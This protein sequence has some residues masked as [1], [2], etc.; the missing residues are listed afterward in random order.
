MPEIQVGIKLRA[1]GQG[2]VGEVRIA[3]EEMEKLTKAAGE[4]GDAAKKAADDGKR[5]SESLK[6]VEK[7]ARAAGLAIAAVSTAV[8]YKTK[9][10]IDN[11]AGMARWQEVTGKSVES[12]AALKYVA[13]Q[14]DV[15]FD[16]LMATYQ[17]LPRAIVEG[18]GKDSEAG[19]AFR[20]IGIDP[21]TIKAND[22]G[23]NLI[24]DRLRQIEDR[25]VRA[26]AAQMIFKQRGEDLLL[27]INQGSE[28]L[29]KLN[30]EGERWNTITG[31]NAQQAKELKDN[32]NT[33]KYGSDALAASIADNTVPA[34]N[35]LIAR[36][37]E[38]SKAS[39]SFFGALGTA[40]DE[41]KWSRDFHEATER[42]LAAQKNLD[43]LNASSGWM[44][45]GLP[46][47]RAELEAARLEVERLQRIKPILI[48]EP[49][50]ASKPEGGAKPSFKQPTLLDLQSTADEEARR[51]SAQQFLLT[52]E[53]RLAALSGEGT[54]VSRVTRELGANAASYTAAEQEA[55]QALAE[56]ID[57]LRQA[58]EATQAYLAEV[59]ADEE[60]RAEVEALKL[61]SQDRINAIREENMLEIEVLEMHL[62]QKR[63][64]VEQAV[65]FE[66][67]SRAEADRQLEL[68][69]IQHQAKLGNAT[70]QGI[71]QRRNLERMGML[72]QAQ[73]YFGHLQQITAAGAQHSRTMFKINQLA[74]I[75]NAIIST[76][77][78]AAK[79]LKWGFPLGPIFAGLIVAAGI[80]QIQA[81]RRAEFGGTSAPSI[82][83]GSAIPVTPA[84]DL[85]TVAAPPVPDIAQAQPVQRR[86]ITITFIGSGRYTQEE[87]RES[88]MPALN[89]ALG[90]GVE[91]R[92]RN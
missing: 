73:F 43:R 23:M 48:P 84:A 67:I 5:H 7:S 26:A 36:L 55:A 2:L 24:I 68:L 44:R 54:E 11:A 61:R 10:W 53:D 76:H 79:A 30:Q 66:Q 70:A 89:E 71:M 16:M 15:S 28:G 78:G 63:Q 33:L 9:Q 87:I 35:T 50:A 29:R 49:P 80:G 17:K 21:R 75:A 8:A 62:E 64:A 52:L 37:R 77:Q 27:W 88:L 91:L 20:A 34:L 12:L 51:R 4:S 42:F 3:R 32:L 39:G 83:G 1:D 69:E 18:L 81:I 72:Q 31:R 86:D 19:R 22:D 74:G 56:K 85:S 65:L 58:K 25:G 45:Q 82:A 6:N 92:V 90:D 14:T 41:Q 47:A 60:V 40:S 57:W 38:G 46:R 13:E 59:A